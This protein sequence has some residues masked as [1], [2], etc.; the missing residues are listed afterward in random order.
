[1]SVVGLGSASYYYYYY[2][3]DVIHRLKLL[4]VQLLAALASFF[5]YGHGSVYSRIWRQH[6]LTPHFMLFL[7]LLSAQVVAGKMPQYHC[8]DLVLLQSISN[9]LQRLGSAPLEGK[10]PVAMGGTVCKWATP[11][12]KH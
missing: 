5:P 3:D 12:L 9:K 10:T 4:L 1:M 11:S 8:H 6:L 2:R 7:L